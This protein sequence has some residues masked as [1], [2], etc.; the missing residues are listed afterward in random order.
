M[1]LFGAYSSLRHLYMFLRATLFTVQAL[2]YFE[3]LVQQQGSVA[4]VARS[5]GAVDVSFE[6][7]VCEILLGRRTTVVGSAELPLTSPPSQPAA[8]LGAVSATTPLP[9][10][11]IVEDWDHADEAALLRR[12]EA[13][14][15][16]AARGVALEA[17]DSA[18]GGVSFQ[19][20]LMTVAHVLQCF[21]H[22]KAEVL[23]FFCTSLPYCV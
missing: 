14:L 5:D 16:M 22:S 21:I 3:R 20:S 13:Q 15:M 8:A 9:Y 19:V 4:A 11:F 23:R 2:S 7:S 6:R 17:E 12:L 10:S 18:E 1:G